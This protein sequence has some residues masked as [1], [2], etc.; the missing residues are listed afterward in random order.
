MKKILLLFLTGMALVS[1]VF[2]QSKKGNTLSVS[3]GPA[4]PIGKFASKDFSD[5]SSG[6]AKPGGAVSLS[7]TKFLS[8]NFG[9][10]LNA[11]AQHNPMDVHALESGF[12]KSLIGYPVWDFDKRSWLYGAVL[13]GGTGQFAIDKKN[14][15]ML[16]TKAMA[17]IAF[18]K[19]PGMAGKSINGTALASVEQNKVSAAG[20][21]YSAEAGINYSIN[22]FVFLTSA[23][24]YN[25]TNKMTYK[26]VKTVITSVQGTPGS[27]DY[28]A[29]QSMTTIDGK[30]TISSVNLLFGIGFRF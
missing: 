17:G 30:Q 3:L 13:F 9:V 8:E 7:F 23:L 29:Q 28:Q 21:T 22:K 12:G 20:F 16:M 27:P 25:G 15:F 4:F 18:A 10:T 19:S 26:D 5:E 14:K 11:Q 6:F 2:S 1:S 24:T